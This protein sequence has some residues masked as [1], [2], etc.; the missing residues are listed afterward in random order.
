MLKMDQKFS[1]LKPVAKTAG[2][3]KVESEQPIKKAIGFIIDACIK[4]VKP[5]HMKFFSALRDAAD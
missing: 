3:F 4:V 2:T 1:L 5:I